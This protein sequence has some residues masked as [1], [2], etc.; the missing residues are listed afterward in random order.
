LDASPRQ[1]I[2][3]WQAKGL[4]PGYHYKIGVRLDDGQTRSSSRSA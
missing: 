2:F 3:N 4:T 1:Y